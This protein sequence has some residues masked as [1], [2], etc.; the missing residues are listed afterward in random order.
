MKR[1]FLK[2]AAAA[3]AAVLLCTGAAQAADFDGTLSAQ[4][5]I[6]VDA[7]SGRVL[8]EKNAD[9]RRLL[10]STTKIMT[11]LLVCDA[12]HLAERAASADEEHAHAE[13]FDQHVFDALVQQIFEQQPQKAACDDGQCVDDRSESRHR[14]APSHGFLPRAS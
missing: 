5:A 7:Q 14:Y 1:R 9:E 6:L 11:G 13:R 8:F 12:Q 10:A 3:V 2:T 4:S